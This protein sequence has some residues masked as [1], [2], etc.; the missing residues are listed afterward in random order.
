[1][2]P[3]NQLFCGKEVKGHESQNQ[4]GC[5]LFLVAFRN[6]VG[7]RLSWNRILETVMDALRRWMCCEFYICSIFPRRWKHQQQQR[8]HQRR[9]YI[10]VKRR[11]RLALWQIWWSRSHRLRDATRRAEST[12][13]RINRTPTSSGEQPSR[14]RC[15]TSHP[16]QSVH[17]WMPEAAL[18]V[19]GDDEVCTSDCLRRQDD[20]GIGRRFADV[21]VTRACISDAMS[22]RWVPDLSWLPQYI[23]RLTMT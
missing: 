12:W 8:R 21:I 20:I 13:W 19:A 16:Q 9:R 7:H 11:R 14:R 4:C 2:S 23:D 10:G 5:W 15:W 6:S 22:Y 3:G 18:V 17:G 1:M